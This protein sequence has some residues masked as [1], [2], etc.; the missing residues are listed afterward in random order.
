MKRATATVADRYSAELDFCPFSEAAQP[1][2]PGK[3][4]NLDF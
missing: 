2:K 3:P 4:G 1:E